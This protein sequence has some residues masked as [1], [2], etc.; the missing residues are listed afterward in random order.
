[1][2]VTWNPGSGE[3]KLGSQPR[4]RGERVLQ[5]AGLWELRSDPTIRTEQGKKRVFPVNRA[6]NIK[7]EEPE[8]KGSDGS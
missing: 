8:Y 5:K 6:K 4:Q 7:V 3:Q 2:S 1:M